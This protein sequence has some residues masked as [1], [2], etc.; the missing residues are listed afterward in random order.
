MSVFT[1]FLATVLGAMLLWIVMRILRLRRLLMKPADPT[2]RCICGYALE[3]LDIPR[4]PECGRLAGF[5]TLTLA[6]VGLTEEQARAN[7]EARRPPLTP[8]APPPT[9]PRMSP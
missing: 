7:I 6:D 8:P 2:R 3:K 5:K 4:C 9:D 1:L